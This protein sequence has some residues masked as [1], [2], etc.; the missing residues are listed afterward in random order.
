MRT[1]AGECEILHVGKAV[2]IKVLEYNNM[3]ENNALK[4]I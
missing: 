3:S 4:K 2:D 1:F